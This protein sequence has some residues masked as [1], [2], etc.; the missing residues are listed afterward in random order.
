MGNKPTAEFRHEVVRVSLTGGLLR[1][2]VAKDFD[3]GFWT[4]GRCIKKERGYVSMS[5]PQTDLIQENE[6]L[7]KEVRMLR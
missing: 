7:R 6:R 5:E 2:Q 1:K 4:L 3:I